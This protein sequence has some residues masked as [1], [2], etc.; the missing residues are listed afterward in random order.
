MKNTNHSKHNAE[1]NRKAWAIRKNAAKRFNCPVMEISWKE[2][3][4]EAKSNSLYHLDKL[5][6]AYTAST[7]FEDLL[8][9]NEN[10]NPTLQTKHYPALLPL[11]NAFDKY[12]Q[13]FGKPNRIYRSGDGGFPLEMQERI[14]KEQL[15]RKQERYKKI[16]QEARY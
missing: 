5:T 4:I 3:L 10:Y 16:I 12:M 7:D 15:I 9:V 13:A 8:T 6:R 14:K 11:A 1:I 2:C